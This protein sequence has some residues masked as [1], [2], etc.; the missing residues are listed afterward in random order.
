MLTRCRLE[1]DSLRVYGTAGTCHKTPP[2]SVLLFTDL[3]PSDQR[4]PL[5]PQWGGGD[6]IIYIGI[7][8]GSVETIPLCLIR[9]NE[10]TATPSS[11]C[12]MVLST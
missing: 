7:G 12:C 6:Y 9:E 4:L 11:V 8:Q 1:F 5:P 10:V 2:H 3:I